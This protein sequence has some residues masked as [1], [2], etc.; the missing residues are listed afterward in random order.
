M[1]EFEMTVFERSSFTKIHAQSHKNNA[2]NTQLSVRIDYRRR[3]T[4][5]RGNNYNFNRKP[6]QNQQI[7]PPC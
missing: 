4:N 1:S 2:E 5:S 3:T 7:R 6:D